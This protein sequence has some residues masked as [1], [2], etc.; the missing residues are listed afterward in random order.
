M[1]L[2]DEVIEASGSMTRWNSLKRFTLQL[3][4]DGTL[5]SR[6]GRTGRFKD[7]VAEGATQ[8]QLVRF[9]GFN[10]PDTCGLYQPDCVMIEGA[11]GQVLRTWRSPQLSFRDH[12]ADA[13]WDEP[14]LI[15]FCGFSL[16][17]YLTT[18]FLLTHPDVRTG[19]LP[20][21]QEHG[22]AWRRLKAIFPPTV[23]THSA[24]QIFY[25]DDKGLQRRTDHDLL[26]TRVAHFSWAHQAFSGIVL[27]TLR[28]S[29]P[30]QP[31][32]TVTPRPVLLDVEIFD[33]SFE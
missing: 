22:H 9:T 8:T 11:D 32:G 29:L 25:F 24:E 17:N 3:S 14:Y 5:L 2:L 27:P 21:V 19:E 12:A 10:G 30:L 23:V 28:R 6:A 33:A 15:F 16:W 26:G 18:P 31:D 20:P 4:I 1:T 7:I 13:P